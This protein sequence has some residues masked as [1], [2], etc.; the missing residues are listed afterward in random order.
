MRILLLSTLLAACAEGTNV[1]GGG[2]DSGAAGDTGLGDTAEDGGDDDSGESLP[3]EWFTLEARLQVLG[4]EAVAD[5]A[6][7]TFLAVAKDRQT[8]ACEVPLVVSGVTIEAP[9]SAEVALWWAFT[10]EA[11]D[12]AC[13]PLPTTI[14]LGVGELGADARAQLGAVGMD[15]VA[16][17]LFGAYL[18][19]DGAGPSLY[20]WAGTE[21]DAAGDDPATLPPPDGVYGLHPLYLV[22]LP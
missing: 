16:E 19:V 13:A 9:D 2:D 21:S 10:V 17:S 20:G 18:Q 12:D 11:A 22:A 4:G 15:T 14:G 1:K 7:V 3:P 8:V 5:G 6:E